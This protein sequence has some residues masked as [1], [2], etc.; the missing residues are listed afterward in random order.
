MFTKLNPQVLN[1]KNNNR[2]KSCGAKTLGQQVATD[3]ASLSQPCLSL[4][5]FMHFSI[6]TAQ[7]NMIIAWEVLFFLSNLR[8]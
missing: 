3:T 2:R 5:Y 1:N 4:L 6:C 8:G 7:V